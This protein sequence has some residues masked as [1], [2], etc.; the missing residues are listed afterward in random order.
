MLK[1]KQSGK[2][3]SMLETLYE[4]NSALRKTVIEKTKLFRRNPH[5]TRLEN[6]ALRKTMKGKWAFSITPDIRIVYRWIGKNTVR[7]LAIGPHKQIY[8]Q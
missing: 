7:F 6:H 1:I 5:D 4:K 8:K 2:Y 3:D